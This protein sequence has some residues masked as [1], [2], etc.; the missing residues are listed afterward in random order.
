MER[1]M[2]GL[3][4][5]RVVLTVAVGGAARRDDGQRGHG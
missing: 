3:E 4:C 2:M 1:R 5:G